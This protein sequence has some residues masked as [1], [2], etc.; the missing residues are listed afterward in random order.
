MKTFYRFIEE[1]KRSSNQGSNRVFRVDPPDRP[2]EDCWKHQSYNI[3]PDGTSPSHPKDKLGIGDT[4]E[5]G[6]KII[7]KRDLV[8]ASPDK[9]NG[10]YA[11]LP[12]KGKNGGP[13]RGAAVY[14]ED[15]MWGD[16]RE[17]GYK[18]T[19]HTTK[20]D[21]NNIPDTVRVSSADAKGFSTE[22]FSGKEETTTS[23][24]PSNIKSKIINSRNLIRSQYNV[25][26]HPNHESI[27]SAI[28]QHQKE[29]T[30]SSVLSSV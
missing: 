28:A 16:N 4:T 30:N 24:S 5:D 25:V 22:N 20:E 23:E 7:G 2:I 14:D 13:V 9:P 29:N 27:R 26:F 10:F 8:F 6:N 11:A 17:K 15:R 3:H 18:G 19:L 1:S 21:W 12:R